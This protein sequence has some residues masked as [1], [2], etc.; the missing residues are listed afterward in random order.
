LLDIASG[1]IRCAALNYRQ[2]MGME[3]GWQ[4]DIWGSGGGIAEDTGPMVP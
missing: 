4:R 1:E 3:T 2:W